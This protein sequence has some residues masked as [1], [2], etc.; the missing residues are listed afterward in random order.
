M[1]GQSISD[2]ARE[3]FTIDE[4]MSEFPFPEFVWPNSLF[5]YDKTLP[6]P[7]ENLALD[8]A[9]L[10]DVEADPNKACLRF[11]EPQEYF[12]VLG[13]S[14]RAETEVNRDVCAREGVRV[15]RRASGGGTVLIGPGCLCYS[16]ALPLTNSHRA[17]GVSSVTKLLM[18]RSAVSLREKLAGVEVCGT[19]DL[20]WNGRKFS[21]NAQRWL[22]RSFLHQGTLLYDFD[23][24]KLSRCLAAPTR[25]PDYRLGRSHQDFVVNIPLS[26]AL[27]REILCSTWHAELADCSAA[28]LDETVRIRDL[29]YT[30]TDWQHGSL[31]PAP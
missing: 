31:V 26:S 23:V 7:S 21:G 4:V 30:S 19:S 6:F 1:A 10:G 2:R 14:N 27:L 29:R 24:S 25:Q 3:S 16:L 28:I 20:V 22:K 15:L 18:E 5:G 11:W 13:R 12:V 9:L 17:L 8:E